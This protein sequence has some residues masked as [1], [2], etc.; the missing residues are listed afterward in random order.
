MA[1][2]GELSPIA[3]SW[4]RAGTVGPDG[5]DAVLGDV[6]KVPAISKLFMLAVSK[7][8]LLDP[9]GMGVEYE[10]GKPGWNDAMNGLC[11]LFG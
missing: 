4:Q 5:G 6:V 9:A 7:F 10:G 1:A 11:G 3:Y 8:T 2:S